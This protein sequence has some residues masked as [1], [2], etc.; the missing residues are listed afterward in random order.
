MNEETECDHCGRRFYAI[1]LLQLGHEMVCNT[2]YE[3]EQEKLLNMF[4]LS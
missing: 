2:C 4:G 3:R 1:D